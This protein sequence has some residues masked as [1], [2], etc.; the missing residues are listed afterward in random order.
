M[1]ELLRAAFGPDPLA[2]LMAA[3]L[4]VNLV[5]GT[6]ALAVALARLPVR[7][8]LGPASAYKLWVIPPLIIFATL[9]L[10]FIP[11]ESERGSAAALAAA[12]AP[13]LGLLAP[14]W[15]LGAVALAALFALAQARFLAEVRAGRAGP[16]VVG[17]IS[18]QVVLPPDDGRY[19]AEERELIRA[20]ERAHV[21]RKDPRAAAFAA[22]SQCLCW[23]NPIAHLAAYL[24]RLDQELACDAAVVMSRPDARGLYA[25]TLLKTQLAATPLPFGCYWSPRGK[26]PLEVRIALLKRTGKRPP[27]LAGAMV[28]AASVVAIRP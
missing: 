22:L 8:A 6:A 15:A 1:S 10:I 2:T 23:F 28:V 7:R 27:G 20:H 5:G 19:T 18:P 13:D 11:S 25:R 26:H 9:L 12:Q 3:F 14:V 16:A 4:F 24:I 17:L 21:A